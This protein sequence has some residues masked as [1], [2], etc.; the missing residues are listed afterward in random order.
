MKIEF[1]TPSF[2]EFTLNFPPEN[3]DLVYQAA[4]AA[5]NG[6]HTAVSEGLVIA[7]AKLRKQRRTR[8]RLWAAAMGGFTFKP[9]DPLRINLLI[10]PST[11]GARRRDQLGRSS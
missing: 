6:C 8:D 2:N 5:A 11:R 3:T 7:K 9:P 4:R 1:I 10:E